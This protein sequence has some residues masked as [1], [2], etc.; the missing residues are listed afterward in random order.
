MKNDEVVG[1]DAWCHLKLVISGEIPCLF[2]RDDETKQ[3]VLKQ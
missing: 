2:Q 1:A 3:A